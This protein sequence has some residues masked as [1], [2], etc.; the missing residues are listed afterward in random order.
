MDVINV[1]FRTRLGSINISF[2]SVV[3]M[4]RIIIRVHHH[5]TITI[6]IITLAFMSSTVIVMIRDHMCLMR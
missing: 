6:H 5:I 3:L 1:S 4:I 2:S